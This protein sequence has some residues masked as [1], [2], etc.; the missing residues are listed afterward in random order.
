MARQPHLDNL[1]L[2]EIEYRQQHI[3]LQSRP[4]Y[5]G[6]VLSNRC[7][8]GC[9]HCYQPKNGDSLL[10][11][12]ALG[13]ELRRE[14][15]GLYPYLSTL[16]MQGGELFAI[17]GFRE[18][19]DDIA[20]VVDRPM[21][22]I[23]T[24]ATLI[25][26]EWAERIVRTPFQNVTISMD[27]GT[28]ETFARLRRG[29][30]FAEV[31]ENTHRI[32][33]WK[34][35]LQSDYPQLDSFFVVMRSNF[36]EIPRFLE[37]AGECGITSVCFQTVEINH[38]NSARFPLLGSNE[39]ITS[40][41]EAVELHAIL[42][43]VV[44]T[45]RGRF[46]FRF[47][48]MTDLFAAHDLD[49]AVLNEQRDGLYPDSDDL[50]TGDIAAPA[51]E[52]CPN[53][54]T[55]LFIV[56]NGDVHLCFLAQPVGN[57]YEMPLSEIWNSPAALAKRSRMIAGRYLESGCSKQWCSWREGSRQP[58]PDREDREAM[59]VELKHLSHEAVSDPAIELPVSSELAPIRRMLSAKDR[60][61]AELETRFRQL[62]DVNRDLHNA[63]QAHI[64]HL[65][66]R[67]K[68]L[69]RERAE[70]ELDREKSDAES[71]RKWEE[72][73]L[74]HEKGQAYIDELEGRLRSHELE[75]NRYRHGLIAR[76][77]HLVGSS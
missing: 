17:T 61:I 30:R 10:H 9:I 58:L 3:Y 49:S 42:R 6:I 44:A 63:G 8:I 38:E 11:S 59:L 71:T 31:V 74:A 36:R 33:R 12:P 57:L 73:R 65:E 21:V 40:R 13:Q 56:E 15:M 26:D 54:W 66:G 47:S 24:N 46:Q 22:S 4:R 19:L 68:E 43:E 70:Q 7:N 76:V 16:R 75:L 53:P 62:C 2:S 48:G 45:N 20:S 67:V 28:P 41:D 35:K 55:T 50:K 27:A 25:D 51:F 37:I 52:L 72:N 60:R 5:L 32:R 18:M 77:R 1:R 69:E 29:G 23:S 14:F 64:D 34:E 39:L